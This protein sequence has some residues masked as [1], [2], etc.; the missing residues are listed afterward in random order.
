MA[1][2]RLPLEDRFA[3]PFVH[4]RFRPQQVHQPLRDRFLR[5]ELELR[6]GEGRLRAGSCS[7]VLLYVRARI[8]DRRVAGVVDR[9]AK[10]VGAGALRQ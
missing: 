8:R 2:R 4:V 1:I 5:I 3:T 7:P 10:V 6:A 9:E